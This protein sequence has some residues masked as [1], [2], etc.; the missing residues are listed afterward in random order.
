[1][2]GARTM[3]LDGYLVQAWKISQD[4]VSLLWAGKKT[5]LDPHLVQ[6]WK[7]MKESPA[8][9]VHSDSGIKLVLKTDQ[10]NHIM[11]YPGAFNPPHRGHVEILEDGFS[12]AGPGLNIVAAVVAP[13]GDDRL[14]E[15]EANR[16]P[17]GPSQNQVTFSQRQRE[18]LLRDHLSSRA[19]AKELACKTQVWKFPSL[20]P[21]DGYMRLVQKLA[22]DDGFAI[23][24]VSLKGAD[25]LTLDKPPKLSSLLDCRAVIFSEISRVNEEAWANG[26]PTPLKGGWRKWSLVSRA[27]G[28]DGVT[29]SVWRSTLADPAGSEVR[30]LAD[31]NAAGKFL[32]SSTAIRGLM[33]DPPKGMDSESLAQ[34]LGKAGAISPQTILKYHQEN[35]LLSLK[36]PAQ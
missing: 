2:T 16:K 21:F 25:H 18:S 1:M 31:D 23:E 10:T 9:S 22:A 28:R 27:T 6:A 24:F 17:P 12:N 32:T 35:C 3:N 14:R 5:Q 8:A 19:D 20:D 11:I 36:G 4:E 26:R 15:K 13:T 34:A 29:R 7:D 30:L 33:M